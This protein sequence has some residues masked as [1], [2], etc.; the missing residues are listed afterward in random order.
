MY[1][2]KS[3]KY[4]WDLSIMTWYF[5]NLLEHH[6]PIPPTPPSH[7]IKELEI[8]GSTVNCEKSFYTIPCSSG[9]D[10]GIA[11]NYSQLQSQQC[12]S[13]DMS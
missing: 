7:S 8:D 4:V 9:L 2:F 10:S 3:D 12:V 13:D 11:E 6:H 1:I 5:I